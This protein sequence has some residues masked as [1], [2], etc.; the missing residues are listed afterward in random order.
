MA[1]KS[2][3]KT[4]KSPKAAT[5]TPTAAESSPVLNT[6]HGVEVLG[7]TKK[8]GTSKLPISAQLS[9]AQIKVK[10]NFNPRTDVGD[11]E[12]LAKSIKADGLLS[13]L[14][15]RP[16]A[17]DGTFELIA[18]ERRYR[19]LESLGWDKPVPVLIR[20]D[21]ADDDR[22]LAVA[23]AENSEDGRTNLNLV[24]LGRVIQELEAKDWSIA[25]IATECG[26]HTQ[27]VRRVAE[28]MK[29]PEAV[30]KKL[31]TGVLSMNAG[32]ELARLDD[33]TRDSVVK[34][35]EEGGAT[36]AADIKRLRKQV[37]TE[38]AV[39]EAEKP[40]G[41]KAKTAASKRVATAWRG[42]REK[43]A[44]L[45]SMCATLVKMERDETDAGF[46]ELRAQVIMLLWD[47][48]DMESFDIP[49]EDAEDTKSKKALK[50][51]WTIVGNEAA[52]A[53]SSGD[54]G[55]AEEVSEGEVESE[56][57]SEAGEEKKPKK[58]PKGKK[59]KKPKE[60]KEPVAEDAA[61][62]HPDHDSDS[63]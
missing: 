9:M 36:S 26:L 40:S 15:V 60:P 61:D 58:A 14:V 27:K 12:P 17:K 19:A 63:E 31:A 21:L 46:L 3:K 62:E 22:A 24:E 42:S 39:V 43:Q 57:E 52:S 35:M 23:V 6:L 56:G 54:E 51:F 59:G 16:S 47:R 28:L 38:E 41:K 53:T 4:P 25:R 8:G 20:T 7:D 50:V 33:K 48:G 45:Q 44:A 1:T 30:R 2:K 37:A 32:L 10:K 34:A 11:L 5:G 55:G 18:G 49:R 13:A 29:Q